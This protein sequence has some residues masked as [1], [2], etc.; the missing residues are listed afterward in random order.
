MD[1]RL[2]KHP[3]NTIASYINPQNAQDDPLSCSY[4][5][6]DWIMMQASCKGQHKVPKSKRGSLEDQQKGRILAFKIDKEG[7]KLAQVQH[8]Y[9]GKDMYLDPYL[10][11]RRVPSHCKC[12]DVLFSLILFSHYESLTYL[13]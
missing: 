3:C 4:R 13:P 5:V 1:N 7:N 8:V 9:M 11:L 2:V 10:C 6:M 12:H